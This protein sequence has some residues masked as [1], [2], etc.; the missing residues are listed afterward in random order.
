MSE[1]IAHELFRTV[2]RPGLCTGC[3]ACIA[4][5]PSRT[6]RMIDTARGPVP[7]FGKASP[8]LPAH[9]L[10]CC[11]GRGIHYPA[12]YR[13][14]FGHTPDR[15]LLGH[16]ESVHT[17]FAADP[18]LRAA[19]ASGGV[20]TRVL[21]FLLEEK[22]IDAAIVVRQDVPTPGQARAVVARTREEILAAAQSVYIPVSTLDVLN[23][24]EPGL[25][26][27]MTCLPDQSAALRALQQRGHPGAQ[28][29]RYVLGPYTGTALEPA[30]IRCFLR[31]NRVR[32]DDALTSLRWRAGDW[33]GYLEI[34]TASGRVLRS[35]K[36]YYNFLIPFFI[37]RNSLQ[38]MDFGNE[39]ADLSVGDAWSPR[40]EAAGGGHSV[41]VTR[42]KEMA[43]IIRTMQE[44]GL[45]ALEPEDPLKAAEMH[46]HMMD[47]KKRGG[48]IR[49]RFRRALGLPATD[50]HMR[51]DP[52]PV[53]RILVELVVSGIFLISRTW[54]ARRIVEAIPERVIGPIFNRLRLGWKN[55]SKP[56]KRKGLAELVMRET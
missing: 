25:R 42:S 14:H 17:G 53:S 23:Q 4:W 26:Y 33:P 55:A 39:F 47:F 18:S 31:Q 10:D 19:G 1:S 52:L 9:A 32:D 38:N 13:Q 3:G 41:V 43:T 46:G 16:I 6:A 20:L 24:L 12:L 8:D 7:D 37:T 5:D 2:V 56:T 34:R 45:L 15:W 36:V 49:N 28:Q 51:P 44:R 50:F 11:P 30:A 22:L 48:Y 21:I 54:L 35:K 40:F 29:I 27:A